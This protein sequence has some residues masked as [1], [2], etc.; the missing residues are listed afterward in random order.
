MI[1]E[2]WMCLMYKFY[3]ELT[4]EDSIDHKREKWDANDPYSFRQWYSE[5]IQNKDTLLVTVGDSWTWGD[6]LGSID[7]DKSVDDPIRLT[8]VF[9]RKLAMSSN[10]FLAF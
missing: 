1:A 7:W 10:N 6:H 9:G 8:Q 5:D 2:Y 4:F 3:K